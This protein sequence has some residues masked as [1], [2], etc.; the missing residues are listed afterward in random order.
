MVALYVSECGVTVDDGAAPI[1]LAHGFT[2]NVNCWASL[3]TELGKTHRLKI[4]DMPGHGRSRH[5][6]VDLSTSGKL[7]A[8]AGNKAHY[9]GYSMGGRIALHVA[10]QQPSLV[11]KLVLIGV[12]PGLRTVAEREERKT[13]DTALA[14]KLREVGLGVFLREW[15]AN[16]LFH[17][18]SDDAAG[19]NYRMDNRVAGLVATLETRSVGWQES[20]W[21]R[22]GDLSMPVLLVA[23]ASDKKYRQLNEDAAAIIPQAET[24][25]IPGSHSVHLEQ[26]EMVANVIRRFLSD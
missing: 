19:I 6:R 11:S 1:V 16:P 24:A 23:G 5:D 3:P 2:Q 15:L 8:E 26:P 7:L 12:S 10:L 20:L 17:G 4:V 9:V 18:L 13:L 14:V 25:V 22:L 21:E